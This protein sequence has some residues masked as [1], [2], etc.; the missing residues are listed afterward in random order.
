MRV[1]ILLSALAALWLIIGLIATFQRGLFDDETSCSTLGHIVGTVFV[2]P[3]N[4][5]GVNPTIEC[6]PLPQPSR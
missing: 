6:P 1:R 3:L 4:Y 5:V 2:G